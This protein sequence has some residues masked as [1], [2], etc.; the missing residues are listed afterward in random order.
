MSKLSSTL[1]NCI[2]WPIEAICFVE[3]R[4]NDIFASE[5]SIFFRGIPRRED[6]RKK[7]ERKKSSSNKEKKK[8]ERTPNEIPLENIHS[9]N[10]YIYAMYRRT[11]TMNETGPRESEASSTRARRII[12]RRHTSSMKSERDISSLHTWVCARTFFFFCYS[13]MFW[14]RETFRLVPLWAAFEL[15]LL[16]RNEIFF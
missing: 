12:I 13:Y 15:L 2:Y 8:K 1:D 14:L 4:A 11:Y 3:Q 9:T 5:L 6:E 16:F 10:S 7:K